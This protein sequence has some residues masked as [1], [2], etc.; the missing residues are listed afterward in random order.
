MWVPAFCFEHAHYKNLNFALEFHSSSVIFLFN[1]HLTFFYIF[2]Y[3][4]IKFSLHPFN[5][6]VTFLPQT[7][8]QYYPE[9]SVAV[10]IFDFCVAN[11]RFHFYN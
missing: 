10:G 8:S 2:I 11:Y 1:Q 5:F 3:W 6:L 4:P 7:R 9:M